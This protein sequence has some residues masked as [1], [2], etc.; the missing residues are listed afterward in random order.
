MNVEEFD[1]RNLRNYPN[2]YMTKIPSAGKGYQKE[3]PLNLFS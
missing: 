3:Q 1:P 2:C